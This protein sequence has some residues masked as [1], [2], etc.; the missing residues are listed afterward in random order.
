MQSVG[1]EREFFYG[2]GFT[3]PLSV[4]IRFLKNFFNL[5]FFLFSARKIVHKVV[6]Q[7][8][9]ALCEACFNQLEEKRFIID[10]NRRAV[11]KHLYGGQ[12]RHDRPENGVCASA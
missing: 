11:T 8:F 1:Q 10:V 3:A 12:N 9:P 6:Q 4:N 7:G 2:Q 5:S